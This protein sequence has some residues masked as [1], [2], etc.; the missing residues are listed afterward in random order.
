MAV[1]EV[2]DDNDNVVEAYEGY[3][4]DATHTDDDDDDV[5]FADEIAVLVGDD[6]DDD[7]NDNEGVTD[8]ESADVDNEGSGCDDEESVEGAAVGTKRGESSRS[9]NSRAE[10]KERAK[11]RKMQRAHADTVEEAIRAWGHSPIKSAP[12]SERHARVEAVLIALKD[13]MSEIA[14]KRNVAMLLQQCIKYG[15]KS[16]RKRIMDALRPHLLTLSCHVYAVHVV[17]KLIRY[18]VVGVYDAV[19]GHARE[20]AFHRI[21]FRVLDMLWRAG[22]NQTQRDALACEF[23]GKRFLALN[24]DTMKFADAIKQE[25]GEEVAA[26]VRRAVE[27][28]VEK[29]VVHLSTMHALLWQYMSHCEAGRES[30]CDLFKDRCLELMGTHDGVIAVCHLIEYSSSKLRKAIVKSWKGKVMEMCLDG[31]GYLA[32]MKALLILDDTVLSQKSILGELYGR[33]VELALSPSGRLV[34]LA[35]LSGSFSTAEERDIIP[36]RPDHAASS[37]K[38]METRLKELRANLVPHLR[39]ELRAAV[40]SAASIACH[41]GNAPIVT[42]GMSAELMRDLMAAPSV[43]R[44]LCTDP[45]AHRILKSFVKEGPED[46]AA[47]VVEYVVGN[48]ADLVSTCAAWIMVAIMESDAHADARQRLRRALRGAAVDGAGAGQQQLRQLVQARRKK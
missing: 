44:Q 45:A 16:Q 39:D 35:V 26:S 12:A 37:K 36:P 1:V 6:D 2:L 40:P 46:V 10:Q 14:V 48:A 32:V 24:T 43:A 33:L 20:L 7:D 3:A 21:G 30:L 38:D 18:G 11:T 27:K 13:K 17:L 25:G 5:G 15:D 47:C 31:D 42:S 22:T 19:K 29:E 9:K 34:L 4:V 8:E 28:C 41:R 23:F